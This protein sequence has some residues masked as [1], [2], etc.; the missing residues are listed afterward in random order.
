MP[1]DTNTKPI[2]TA[3]VKIKDR[4]QSRF[5]GRKG[6]IVGIQPDGSNVVVEWENGGVQPIAKE[7]LFKLKKKAINSVDDLATYSSVGTPYANMVDK[8]KTFMNFNGIKKTASTSSLKARIASIGGVVINGSSFAVDKM[9][10]SDAAIEK[11]A[12]DHG[13]K[14]DVYTAGDNGFI[15]KVASDTPFRDKS[16]DDFT[17]FEPDYL[18]ESWINGNKGEVI[19]KCVES[20]PELVANVY[21]ILEEMVGDGEASS[22]FGTVL[23]SIESLGGT[24]NY[25]SVKKAGGSEPDLLKDIDGDLGSLAIG[26]F[27]WAADNHNGQNSLGYE[28]LSIL[29]RIYNPKTTVGPETD[30]LEEYVYNSIRSEEEALD[31]AKYVE[32]N[33]S[34]WLAKETGE[35]QASVKKY[36]VNSS[37]SASEYKS[38]EDIEA[39]FSNYKILSLEVAPSKSGKGYIGSIEVDFPEA[40]ESVGGGTN[41]VYDNFIVYDNNGDRIA[42]D[43]WYP[44]EVVRIFKQKIK[45]EIGNQFG[46]L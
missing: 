18:A 42:F 17:G 8:E 11:L 37:K 14:I 35:K 28:A 19:R 12:N 27:W 9:S 41:Y 46:N 39:E 31:I 1:K 44:D 16:D 24:T 33:I 30:S 2:E 13:V 36:S 40:G 15:C 43:N 38:D 45:E 29:G 4:V 20:G 22:F 7:S 26:A 23:N 25:A 3:E 10:Y 21:D 5:S 6:T 32:A 34:D